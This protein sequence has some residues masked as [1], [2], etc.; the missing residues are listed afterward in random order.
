MANG[1]SSMLS[2]CS[3][4]HEVLGQAWDSLGQAR[5]KS[6]LFF[7][8]RFSFIL[9]KVTQLENK[10]KGIKRIERDQRGFLVI[11]FSIPSILLIPVNSASVKIS[12]IN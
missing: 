6:R 9:L 12:R 7:R 1:L 2:T 8:N 4:S 5:I 11:N 10:F 3:L